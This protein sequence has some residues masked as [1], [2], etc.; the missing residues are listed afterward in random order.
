M[1]VF[2]VLL[3]SAEAKAVHKSCG[4]NVGEI[5]PLRAASF[6][7][8][9]W[10]KAHMPRQSLFSVIGHFMYRSV[11]PTKLQVHSTLPVPSTRSYARHLLCTLNA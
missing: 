6:H 5:E 7:Q 9:F 4:K 3:G 2:F 1:T 10:H 11:S 8:L